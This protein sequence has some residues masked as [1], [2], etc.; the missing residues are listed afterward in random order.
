[1]PKFKECCGQHRRLALQLGMWLVGGVV[2][3]GVFERGVPEPSR[4][5]CQPGNDD[6]VVTYWY[7]RPLYYR[8][9][10]QQ[11]TTAAGMRKR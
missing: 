2:A 7:Y 8:P 11:M 4:P 10:H 9:N 1:M 3:K 6:E 5:A